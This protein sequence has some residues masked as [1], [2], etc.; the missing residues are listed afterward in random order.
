MITKKKSSNPILA[1]I[2]NEDNM[3]VVYGLGAAVVILGALFKLQGWPGANIML[4]VGLGVEALIFVLSAFDPPTSHDWDWSK[5]YPQLSPDGSATS[6]S[7]VG[8]IMKEAKLDPSVIKS[9]GDGMKKM[10]A[11]A[12]N[13]NDLAGAS[14]AAKAYEESIK[15]ATSSLNSVNESYSAISATAKD[16]ADSSASVKEAVGLTQEYKENLKSASNSLGSIVAA[17]GQITETAANMSKA[18]NDAVKLQ[19]E[20]QDLTENLSKLNKI[21]VGMY[22]AM[23]K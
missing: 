13:I 4:I 23:H 1:W 14:V 7:Q 20:L 15:G 22:D 16:L 17:S 3:N 2:Q 6:A 8:N 9:V 12:N 11:Q 19:K 5:V 18:Q 10:A 21:Y